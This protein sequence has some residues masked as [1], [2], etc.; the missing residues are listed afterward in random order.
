MDISSGQIVVCSGGGAPPLTEITN[1]EIVISD[2]LT[3]NNYEVGITGTGDIRRRGIGQHYGFGAGVSSGVYR[4]PLD[5]CP[6]VAMTQNRGSA[7]SPSGSNTGDTIII[8]GVL[9]NPDPVPG[10]ASAAVL[11]VATEN[12]ASAAGQLGGKIIFQT[13][14]NGSQYSRDCNRLWMKAVRSL[15]AAALRLLFALDV[16][17]DINLS[18]AYRRGGTTGITTVATLAKI[19]GGGA[20]GSLTIAGGII[21]GYVAPT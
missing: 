17:G 16:T 1:G 12:Q 14:P 9:G 7:L 21:T 19:T 20:N 3:G 10:R 4:L 13:A 8:G 6:V 5:S 2:D 11:M 15:S 18:G